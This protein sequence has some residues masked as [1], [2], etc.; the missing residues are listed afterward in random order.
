VGHAL[1][2]GVLA[3]LR[4]VRGSALAVIPDVV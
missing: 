3:D 4:L 1:P 2:G